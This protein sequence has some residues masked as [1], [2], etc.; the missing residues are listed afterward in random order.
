MS[1]EEVRKEAAALL[2]LG[3][4]FMASGFLTMGSAYAIRI[5]IVHLCGLPSAGFYQAAWTFGGVCVGFI[6]QAMGTDFYPRLC[7]VSANSEECNRLVN[8]QAQI[9]LLLAGPGV[10]ATLTFA[11]LAIVLFY[12]GE[13]AAAVPPLRWICL[14]LTLRVV[15]WPMGFILLAKKAQ[16]IFLLTE[17]AAVI[18]H[19]GLAWICVH[20]FGLIGAGTAFFG[21]YV[22][23]TVLIYLVV[24]RLTGFRWST[25]NKQSVLVVFSLA[26]LVFFGFLVASFW[27]ATAIGTFA[28]LLASVYSLRC[29]LMLIPVDRIPR[30]IRRLH[31]ALAPNPRREGL[32]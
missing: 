31:L 22:W 28:T 1:F 13:F 10:M 30:P 17:L 8:E 21:L 27:V 26:G 19:V 2:S 16:G 15:A 18:V 29:L 23:H 3:F 4:A 25:V 12:S 14:G 7:A 32:E 5:M 24:R 9:S 6:L 20:R 11:P